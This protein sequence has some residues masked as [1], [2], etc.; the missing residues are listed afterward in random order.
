MQGFINEIIHLKNQQDIVLDKL[1]IADYFAA[2]AFIAIK[3]AEGPNILP[4]L[5]Y[6]RKDADKAEVKILD[7]IPTEHNAKERLTALGFE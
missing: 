3:E 2:A 5:Q 7:N 6:G 1:S 4:E